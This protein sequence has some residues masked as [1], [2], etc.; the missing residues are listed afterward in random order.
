MHALHI[1]LQE[2]F[3]HDEIV[4]SLDGAQVCHHRDLS[5]RPQIG[6]AAS[7]DAD[8]GVGA[9]AMEVSMPARGALRRIQPLDIA[10]DT[11]VGVS[12]R[13]DGQFDI[14]VSATPFGY[15]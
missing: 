12:V 3:V 7:C 10:G 11:W 8:V 15:L 1:A 2:G 14:R 13:P 5:T 6:L 9:H 4:V